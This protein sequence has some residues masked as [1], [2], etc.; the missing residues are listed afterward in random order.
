MEFDAVVFDVGNVLVRL[1]P[2]AMTEAFVALGAAPD[3]VRKLWTVT[4]RSCEQSS[5]MDALDLGT[6]GVPEFCEAMR[7]ELA[8][9]AALDADIEDAWATL[10]GPDDPGARLVMETLR[11]RGKRVAIL[12]NNNDMHLARLAAR[13]GGTSVPW[14][15]LVD[16]GSFY[17]NRIGMRKPSPEAFAHV[18]AATG[19]DPRSTLF[20]DDLATNCRAAE[21]AGMRAVHKDAARPLLNCMH[22]A[23]VL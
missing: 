20:V 19:F 18:L 14:E 21:G 2:D 5:L 8:I 12:S 3:A 16:A 7:A 4:G 13:H 10:L 6:I 22:D 9:P 17:S 11:A 15:S 23:G 1:Q